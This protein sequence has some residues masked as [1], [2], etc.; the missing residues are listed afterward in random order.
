[1]RQPVDWQSDFAAAVLRPDLP[2]PQGLTDPSGELSAKRFAVYRNN[3][4]AGLIEVLK[5]TF[6]V[7]CRIVGD[8]F[9]A[10]MAKIYVAQHPPDSP[11]LLD[12]GRG[13]PEFVAS[14]EPAACLSYLSDV[15]RIERAWL[16][17]YH[18]ADASSIESATFTAPQRESVPAMRVSLHPS[19]SLIRSA[20]PAF[21]IWETNTE[22]NSPRPIELDTNRE[23]GLIARP[24]AN[25]E[26]RSLTEPEFVFLEAL[27]GERTIAEASERAKRSGATFDAMEALAG[28]MELGLIIRFHTEASPRACGEGEQT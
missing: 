8:E 26:V 4:V 2:V 17:A 25:V 5:D 13:F 18:A 28:V 6:P 11:I 1:M 24:G 22:G 19:L 21:T 27:S 7:T 14:F 15:C 3:V 9:F 16:D 23:R 20:F 12:Y 10:A